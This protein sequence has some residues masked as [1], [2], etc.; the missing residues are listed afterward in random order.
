MEGRQHETSRFLKKYLSGLNITLER[1]IKI[2]L[3]HSGGGHRSFLTAAGVLAAL[4]DIGILPCI[5]YISGISG[6]S[7][8][9]MSLAINEFKSPVLLRDTVWDF[10][11]PLLKGVPNFDVSRDGELGES[12]LYKRYFAND[13]IE[14]MKSVYQ[15]YRN[16]HREVSTKRDAGFKLSFTDYWGRIIARNIFPEFVDLRFSDLSKLPSFQNF[17]QPFPILIS[18]S[19]TNSVMHSSISSHVVEVNLF[20]FGSFESYLKTFADVRYLGTSLHDGRPTTDWCVEG[21]DNTGFI[22]ATSSSLFDN[23]LMYFSKLVS[24]SDQR[25]HDAISA[26][27]RIFN[28]DLSR[29]EELESN[30]DYALYSPNPFLGGQA[31]ASNFSENPTLFLVDGGSDGQNIPFQPLLQ[32]ERDLDVIFATDCSSDVYNWPNGSTLLKTYERYSSQDTNWHRQCWSQGGKYYSVFPTIPSNVSTI[33]DKPIFFGCQPSLYTEMT[34]QCNCD[35]NDWIP[36][37]IVYMANRQHTFASNTSTFQMAYPHEEVCQMMQNGYN[38][39]SFDN[40]TSYM[41]C[42][43]CVLIKRSYDRGKLTQLPAF[44]KLCLAQYC[45]N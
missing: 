38:V 11:E 30:S 10:S 4:D 32:R 18:N 1:N 17:T 43:K 41:E 7:W 35:G 39:A 14:E 12:K 28:L 20:E 16:I 8:L 44:C 27:M 22:T 37:I 31:M 29:L 9:V 2:G 40:S 34:S 5:S 25:T 36:P 15:F 23:V 45:Y 24:H 21:F 42:L 19:H 26:V 33:I 3:A 13:L 6:G